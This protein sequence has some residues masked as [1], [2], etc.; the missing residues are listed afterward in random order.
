MGMRF[1]PRRQARFTLKLLHILAAVGLAGGLAAY[2]IV[3]MAVPEQADLASHATVRSGLAL[4]AKWLLVPSMLVGLVSGLLSMAVHYPYMNAPWVW[5]KALSGILL[6]EATLASID[7][8][9]QGAA[10]VMSQ[11]VAGEVPAETVAEMIR[12]EWGAWWMIL[13]LSVANVVL[14]IWRPRFGMKND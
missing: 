5:A 13:A 11:A 6:F 9:A 10:L 4:V 8:P 14:G 2:M 3:L 7:A 1:S 12:D